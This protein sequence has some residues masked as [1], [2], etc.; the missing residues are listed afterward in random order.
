MTVT[1]ISRQEALRAFAERSPSL[2]P[3]ELEEVFSQWLAADALDFQ[4][5][6]SGRWRVVLRSPR[7]R[8]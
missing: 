8:Q 7:T 6:E 5:D 1:E 2:S 4:R 3:S